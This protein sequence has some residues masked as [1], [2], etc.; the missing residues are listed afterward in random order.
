MYE[1]NIRSVLAMKIK[2]AT[3][4]VAHKLMTDAVEEEI[5]LTQNSSKETVEVDDS[6][7]EAIRRLSIENLEQEGMSENES[8]LTNTPDEMCLKNCLSRSFLSN[9]DIEPG[10]NALSAAVIKD[11]SC[12]KEAEKQTEMHIPTADNEYVSGG[13]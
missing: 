7:K 10:K 4:D 9:L 2:T 8:K 11:Q 6:N 5:K 12:I 13:Y 1:L 3:C